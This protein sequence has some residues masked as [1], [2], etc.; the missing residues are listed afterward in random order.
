[1][2]IK[3]YALILPFCALLTSCADEDLAM[4][5][6]VTAGAAANYAGANGDA[7]TASSL[8]ATQQQIMNEEANTEA[9]NAA[10]RPTAQSAASAP[11]YVSASSVPGKPGFAISPTTGKAVDV[12]GIPPGTLVEDPTSPGSR[13]RVPEN[14]SASQNTTSYTP[15]ATTN[16]DS[17]TKSTGRVILTAGKKYDGPSEEE[18]ERAARKEREWEKKYRANQDEMRLNAGPNYNKQGGSGT[19]RTDDD[20]RSGKGVAR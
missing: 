7:A 12:D 10:R 1:M 19:G 18:Q 14:S 2:K 15:S 17:S 20:P 11:S 16:S 4:L 6:A 13:F 3:H 9:Y 5:G 8:L